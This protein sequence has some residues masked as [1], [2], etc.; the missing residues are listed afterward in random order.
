[1]VRQTRKMWTMAM[2]RTYADIRDRQIGRHTT[3][4]MRVVALLV[5]PCFLA[6]KH[7]E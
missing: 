3:K 1:M 4:K 7:R 6:N 5:A 2:Q